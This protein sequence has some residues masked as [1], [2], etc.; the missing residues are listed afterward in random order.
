M[1]GDGIY[2]TLAATLRILG[3]AQACFGTVVSG[4]ERLRVRSVMRVEWCAFSLL[5]V[6]AACSPGQAVQKELMGATHSFD[7]TAAGAVPSVT[8]VS[9]QEHGRLTIVRHSP[10]EP[11]LAPLVDSGG[12]ALKWDDGR[13]MAWA[14]GLDWR[15]RLEGTVDASAELDVRHELALSVRRSDSTMIASFDMS[16]GDA[17]ARLMVEW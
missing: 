15:I 5:L 16:P 3:D 2:E 14:A 13:S 12:A 8:L 4:L 7:S 17:A 9:D 1:K 10:Q 11:A 6:A